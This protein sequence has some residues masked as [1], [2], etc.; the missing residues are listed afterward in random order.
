M[1]STFK[2]RSLISVL[3]G[4]A[5]VVVAGGGSLAGGAEPEAYEMLE[6]AGPDFW[7]QLSTEEQLAQLERHDSDLLVRHVYVFVDLTP[8]VEATTEPV[9]VSLQPFHDFLIETE[10]VRAARYPGFKTTNWHSKRGS[11]SLVSIGTSSL[12]LPHQR[13]LEDRQRFV[14][15]SIHH[16][17]T[18]LRS[19]EVPGAP[20]VLC[21]E[22]TLFTLVEPDSMRDW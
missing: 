9:R 21:I 15:V 17:G 12:A 20:N 7:E 6:P 3:A 14:G 18:S 22:E 13:G 4:L 10:M 1:V 19:H 8:I 11:K 5:L 16:K 2:N